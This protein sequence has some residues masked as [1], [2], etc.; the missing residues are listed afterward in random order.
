MKKTKEKKKCEALT[1][2]YKPCKRLIPENDKYCET[3]EEWVKFT[4][5]EINKIRN[6]NAKKCSHCKQLHLDETYAFCPICQEKMKE[7]GIKKRAEMIRCKGIMKKDGKPC[8]NRPKNNTAYCKDHDYMVDYTKEQLN[9]LKKCSDCKRYIFIEKGYKV[10]QKCLERGKENRE[11]ISE[12]KSK[13][14]MCLITNC[15][16]HEQP[17]QKNGYCG[18]HQ[19]KGWKFNVEKDGTKKVCGKWKRGCRNILDINY[20]FV[21]CDDCRKKEREDIKT[22]FYG[23]VKSARKRDIKLVM[24]FEDFVNNCCAVCFYCEEI[25]DK[26]WNGFDRIDQNKTV[27]YDINNLIPCCKTCNFMRQDIDT[28]QKFINY[29]INIH[30][31]YKT[32]QYFQNQTDK[33]I[34]KKINGAKAKCIKKNRE[35]NLTFNQV[36]NIVTQ[37][38]YY[39]GNTNSDKIGMDR[40]DPDKGYIIDNCVPCCDI[41]NF[42]KWKFPLQTFIDKVNKIY[43]KFAIDLPSRIESIGYK[44]KKKEKI[45]QKIKIENNITIDSEED[46]KSV[47]SDDN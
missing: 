15:R 44:Q 10:C 1:G 35:Y 5:E 36:K 32:K 47:Y 18:K 14:P 8:K 3:H 7:Y 46:Y 45:I 33:Y 11:K 20:Q 24:S 34:N 29:C 30:N 23:Y 41:C 9:N 28:C 12:E 42:M 2:T 40:V 31:N 4:E 26:K 19:T 21:K 16:Y 22:A 13:T 39:C 43:K 27:G 25:D 6:G 38:C 17:E 37:K